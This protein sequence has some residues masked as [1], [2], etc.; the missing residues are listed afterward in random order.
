VTPTIDVVI[1]TFNGWTH[2]ER[3]LQHLRA[4]TVPHRVI[5]SDN[6]SSD[7]TQERVLA[8]FP[9]ATLIAGEGNPGFPHACNRGVE[10]GAGDIVVL[11]NNDV[12]ARPEFLE[13]LAAP[14]EADP[15][16]GS[17]C[18]TLLTADGRL[19]DSVGLSAD[20]TLAGWPRLRG[21]PADEATVPTPRLLGPSGGAGAY[22]RQAW[23][24]VG[25]LDEGVRFY[26][27]DVEL[28]LR[29]RAA[30]W[31][32][33]A[34]PEAVALHI[35]SA[36]FGVRSVAQREAAGFARAY[37]IGR[38]GVLRSRT[39]VR[40]VVTEL[41]VGG[42]DALLY[43]DLAALRG[44]ARG[45]RASRGLPRRPMPAGDVA[46]SRIG[47]LASL[48]M[49]WRDVAEPRRRPASAEAA[50][51]IW[52]LDDG[53]IMGGGQRFALRM[54]GVLTH[55]DSELRLLMPADSQVAIE[56]RRRGYAI[57]DA[58]FPNLLPP[59]VTRIPTALWKLRR[60]LADAPPGTIIVGNTA[61]CQAYAT[62][63]AL[64]VRD[65]PRLVHLMHEQDS[66]GRRTARAVYK[67][68]GAL[69]A[70]G[71]N[72]ADVY[73][74]HLPG[75]EVATVSN[76]I[77]ADEMRR[78]DSVRTPAPGSVKPVVG[79]LAR[80]IPEKGVLDLVEE[81]AAAPH[82]WSAARIA[83]PP[84]DRGYT[85]RVVARVAELQL[86]DRIHLLGEISDLDAF[87]STIDVLVVPSVGHEGQPT[88]II[89]SLLYGRP[90]IVRTPIWAERY[91]GMPVTRY[92]TADDL[93]RELEQLDREPLAVEQIALR[94]GSTELVE[95]LRE[96]AA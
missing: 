32:P 86:E 23:E 64:T 25:G 91:A 72:S 63:A 15:R 66:A 10:A 57:A 18:A 4:Q 78:I 29:L 68:F 50:P 43:R 44:R 76:F 53:L 37:F 45:L 54:A 69:V 38:Y 8:D 33:A 11:L 47:F 24:E 3:C 9:E 79:V 81:L 27:E 1:P 75:V 65:R 62:A 34:A 21:R 6:G 51:A 87:F 49:R 83:A 55:S 19:I 92:D 17:A 42:A 5:V 40:T 82:A 30:G 61:R 59:A 7:G 41:I 94:F 84:Q 95:T 60:E 56:A 52:I 13:R 80:M 39:A 58:Q 88:V 85:Q 20:A 96:L 70:V 35:G 77:D 26:S 71:E 36:T 89:E 22:R 28:A 90:V 48:R 73:R 14:F 74:R 46:E 93:R 31:E 67:R 16:I 2:T 12:D